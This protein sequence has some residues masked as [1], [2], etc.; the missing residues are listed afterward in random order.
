MIVPMVI[1]ESAILNTLKNFTSMKSVTDPEVNLSIKFPD[2]PPSMSPIATERA[3]LK[4]NLKTKIIITT[5][6]ILLI[7]IKKNLPFDN[8]PN[9]APMFFTR[10][11]EI[12][13]S[14]IG[15]VSPKG[16]L[17]LTSHFV[18]WSKIIIKSAIKK[19]IVFLF[20]IIISFIF[21]L[22]LSIPE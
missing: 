13:L 6:E 14:I 22:I 11:R 2:I 9:A 18:N 16:I 19:I 4:E 20:S 8:I 7:N 17:C 10:V 21:Q 5:I 12:N 15:M 3:K 1:A